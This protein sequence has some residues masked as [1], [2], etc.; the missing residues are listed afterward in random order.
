M[1]DNLTEFSSKPAAH[2]PNASSTQASPC[3][4]DL[5]NAALQD[6]EDSDEDEYCSAEEDIGPDESECST[7]A[8]KLLNSEPIIFESNKDDVTSATALPKRE[9]RPLQDENDLAI[10]AQ[11]DELQ[12]MNDRENDTPMV[13]HKHF[14]ISSRQ[15]PLSHATS[16]H[17]SSEE[18][19]SIPTPYLTAQELLKKQNDHYYSAVKA[20]LE[21]LKL[22]DDSENDIP[23]APQIEFGAS[24]INVPLPQV[25]ESSEELPMTLEPYMTTSREPTT[26]ANVP[27][28]SPF[29]SSAIP[30]TSSAPVINSVP[31][32]VAELTANVP[33]MSGSEDQEMQSALYQQNIEFDLYCQHMNNALEED[34]LPHNVEDLHE[35][36]FDKTLQSYVAC[37]RGL[38]DDAVEIGREILIENLEK[39]LKQL[40]EDAQNRLTIFKLS[41]SDEMTNV[42]SEMIV[43]FQLQFSDITFDIGNIKK[44]EEMYATAMDETLNTF[45]LITTDMLE[46]TNVPR[47][48]LLSEMSSSFKNLKTEMCTKLLSNAEKNAKDTF[49]LLY[50][51]ERDSFAGD[52]LNSAHT[53]FIESHVVEERSRIFQTH[54]RNLANLDLNTEDT[55]LLQHSEALAAGISSFR[56]R[57]I[58]FP[59]HHVNSECVLLQQDMEQE[60]NN[61]LLHLMQSLETKQLNI[62][63][64]E[65]REMYSAVFELDENSFGNEEVGT[66]AMELSALR[67]RHEEALGVA[68]I[69]FDR[70]TSDV[71]TRIVGPARNELQEEFQLKLNNSLKRTEDRVNVSQFEVAA[72]EARSLYMSMFS[73]GNSDSVTVNVT[74]TEDSGNEVSESTDFSFASVGWEEDNEEELLFV[75]HEDDFENLLES[76]INT[77]G[78]NAI[79]PVNTTESALNQL[80]NLHVLALSSAIG[81]FDQLT[82]DHHE[83][84]TTLRRAQLIESLENVYREAVTHQRNQQLDMAENRALEKFKTDLNVAARDSDTWARRRQEVR[85]SALQQ[86]NQDTSYFGDAAASHRERLQRAMDLSLNVI[87]NVREVGGGDHEC[88]ICLTER[89][90]TAFQPCGHRCCS[91]CAPQLSQCPTCRGPING[92]L[93][94]Y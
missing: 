50:T 7:S 91:M 68:L 36:N 42:Y 12:S 3:K 75:L 90:N 24:A 4:E 11:I 62:A 71:D 80:E 76:S 52:V 64:N 15:V 47:R 69:S 13:P 84:D 39:Y 88:C 17:E 46:D 59:A 31:M 57:T 55:L 37:T 34:A 54:Q 16:A 51:T 27:S 25:H 8:K 70:I 26:F 74:S 87:Q 14:M 67:E 30:S 20:Q 72:T 94:I 53:K 78:T 5:L 85:E 18:V 66:L 49:E 19:P 35:M 29:V 61:R 38:G 82:A 86:F 22:V 77:S 92:T 23:T 6:E 45:D 89:C 41:M 10:Q 21:E 33:S 43:H 65:A 81:L 40:R 32:Q 44:A 2:N 63:K 9:N 48:L 58:G 1:N 28:V 83:T 56:Q 79:A 60:L 73:E 93:R